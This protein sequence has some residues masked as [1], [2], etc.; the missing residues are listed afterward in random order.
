MKT[1]LTEIKLKSAIGVARQLFSRAA[2]LGALILICTSASAQ[3]GGPPVVTTKPATFIASF[4]AKLHGALNPHGLSTTFHFQY[5]A[6]TKYGLTTAPQ[7]QT[8]NTVR[9]VNAN[10]SSLTARTTYHFRI[11]AS[12]ADGTTYGSDETLTTLTRTGPPV[13]MTE[14]ADNSICSSN[15]HCTPAILHGLVDPHGLVTTVYFQWGPG[16]AFACLG[17]F[18][19]N[20]TAPGTI[21]GNTYKGVSADLNLP[22]HTPTCPGYPYIFRIV[23]TN[24]DGTSY[25]ECMSFESGCCQ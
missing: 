8:G 4:S 20:T 18:Y 5:G 6:T 16:G 1:K 11:V 3:N 24:S 10:I 2:C 21:S 15:C 22:V 19:P 12:N 25:G 23:A 17:G 9:N 14:P 7:T 13:V